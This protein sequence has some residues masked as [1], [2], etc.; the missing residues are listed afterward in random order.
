[1]PRIGTG[2]LTQRSLSQGFFD[3]FNVYASDLYFVKEQALPDVSSMTMEKIIDDIKAWGTALEL[4]DYMLFGHS[5]YGIVALEFSKKY[6]KL[7]THLLLTGTP[8]NSTPQVAAHHD[9]LFQAQA[10]KKRKQLDAE[11][12]AQIAQQDLTTLSPSERWARE[13]IY[14][15]APRYWHIPDYDCSHLWEGIILDRFMETFF[16]NILPNIDVR[17]NLSDIQTPIFLAAGLNDYDCCPWLWQ[18]L[19]NLPPLM[20]IQHFKE[21]GHWPQY[22]EA[23]LFNRKVIEWINHLND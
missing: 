4:K 1:M 17:K 19:S 13:Y 2:I 22:E 9:Q 21:S 11:R 6:P 10:D 12:R 23:E 5:A 8:A 14:R 15:D 20:T 16:A 18:D 7:A 3:H